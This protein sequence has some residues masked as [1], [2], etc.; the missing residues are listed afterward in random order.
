MKP[1]VVRR[2]WIRA[3]LISIVCVA[4]F[5]ALPLEPVASSDDKS[6]VSFPN[7]AGQTQAEADA[8]SAGCIS[9]H[10]STD[11]ASMHTSDTVKLGCVDCHGGK[12]DIMLP[13]ATA[14]NSPEYQAAKAKAHVPPRWLQDARSSAN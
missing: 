1:A 2:Y 4:L 10:S 11:S 9:C 14:A 12:P 5:S 6:P 7:L 8:K 13:S 3:P